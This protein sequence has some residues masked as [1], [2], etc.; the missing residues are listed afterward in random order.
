[1]IDQFAP[2]YEQLIAKHMPKFA[3]MENARAIKVWGMDTANGKQ[4]V[5]NGG[6]QPEPISEDRYNEAAQRYRS[7]QK[8]KQITDE[9]KISKYALSR[10]LAA[11]GLRRFPAGDL[12]K[13]AKI[14][15]KMLRE[16]EKLNDIAAHLSISR[17]AVSDWIKR[18]G[19]DKW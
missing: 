6:R 10:I 4:L 2:C 19:I 5:Q 3:K 1:M 18:Y 8:F 15:R 11:E 13:K 16:G 9:M 7:G 17:Q 12:P 14:I